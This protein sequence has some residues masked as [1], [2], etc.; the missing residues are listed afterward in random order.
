MDPVLGG[1][2]VEG[3]ELVAVLSEL[4]G[5]LGPLGLVV[6]DEAVEGPLRVLTVLGVTDLF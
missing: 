4:L 1:E 6:G 5:R 3:E 2:G